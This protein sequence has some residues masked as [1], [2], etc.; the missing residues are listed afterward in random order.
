MRTPPLRPLLL[1]ALL[2][3]SAPAWAGGSSDQAAGA[4]L[5]DQAK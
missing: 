4:A 5:F 1:A 3:G 2:T